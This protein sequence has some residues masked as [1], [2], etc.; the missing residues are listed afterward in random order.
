MPTVIFTRRCAVRIS[1]VLGKE[2]LWTCSDL[3]QGALQGTSLSI[4]PHFSS[5]DD[6]DG[7]G[8]TDY[9]N[10]LMSFPLGVALRGQLPD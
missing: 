6:R 2:Y 10:F 8:K 1:T 3:F 7:D 4:L 9:A 5:D